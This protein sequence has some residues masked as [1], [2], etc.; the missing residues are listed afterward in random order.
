LDPVKIFFYLLL[1]VHPVSVAQEDESIQWDPTYRL[2]WDDFRADPP[3]SQRVAATTASGISYSYR[4]KGPSGNYRL[5]YEVVAYF[6]PER[7]WYHPDLCDS[8]VLSHE[9]LHFDISEL[10][11]R[12]MREILGSRTF[13]GNV[14]AEVRKIFARINRELS[15]FQNRYDMETDFSRDHEAQARWNAQIAE[16]LAGSARSEMN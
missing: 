16:R 3:R 11:A 7:S 13:D 6:Y 2:T 4:T 9:Q 14:R 15:E 10:Y 5:D 1:I 12:R 8:V